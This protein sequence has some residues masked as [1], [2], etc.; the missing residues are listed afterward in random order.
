MRGIWLYLNLLIDVG[1]R[2]VV[3]WDVAEREGPAIAADLV[4]KA[5]L[6]EKISKR[7]RQPLILHADNGY[8]MRASTLESRLEKLGVLRWFS[9]P[10]VSND[11]HYSESP[12]RTAKYRPAYPRRP[13]ASKDEASQW[14]ASFANWYNHR[15]RHSGMK[16]VPPH[17][18][19]SVQA[20]ETVVTALWSTRRRA[21]ETHAGGY[22]QHADGVNHRWS[23]SIHNQ[24]NL[25]PVQ[26]RCGW[27]LE[28][29]Q[30]R[31]LCWQAPDPTIVVRDFNAK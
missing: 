24:Q 9:R 10:H 26:L 17:Q 11:N 20:T 8:A 4:S 19:N 16:F 22:D 25:T 23:G 21:S 14:V 18:R 30:G 28:Q 31:H 13:F 27:L 5:C 1:S 15:H 12:F 29:Q 2:K 6:R 7:R 3:A